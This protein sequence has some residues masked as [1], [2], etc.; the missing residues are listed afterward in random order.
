VRLSRKRRYTSVNRIR[1]KSLICN[2]KLRCGGRYYENS[3]LKLHTPV[4][5]ARREFCRCDRNA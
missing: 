1:Q 4:R 2:R 5:T 3:V